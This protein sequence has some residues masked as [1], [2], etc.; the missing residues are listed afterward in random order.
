M[1]LDLEQLLDLPAADRLE[2]AEIL[3]RS[4]GHPDAVDALH[5][6]GWQLARQLRTLRRC[7]PEAAPGKP[8]GDGF[9][10]PKKSPTEVGLWEGTSRGPP[11][12]GERS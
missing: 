5:L 9:P 6:P 11:K 8:G 12:G 2:L 10:R 7:V 4:V 1:P 3:R